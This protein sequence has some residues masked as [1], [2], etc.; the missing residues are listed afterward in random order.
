MQ[1]LPEECVREILLRLADHNDLLNAA[2]AYTMAH[3]VSISFFFP[4][5]FNST[6]FYR[7]STIRSRILQ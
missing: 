1:D 2:E 4:F 6:E 7:V 3:H 5:D